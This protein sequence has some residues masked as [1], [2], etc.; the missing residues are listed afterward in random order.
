MPLY[1]GK[2]AICTFLQNMR[3]MLRSHDRYKPVSLIEKMGTQPTKQIQSNLGKGRIV[4]HFYSAGG[5]SNLQLRVLAV[6]FDPKSPLPLGVR[7]PIE[8]NVSL[9]PTSVPGKWHLNPSNGLSR[10]HERDR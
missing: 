7:D 2:Y 6:G 10:V 8:H 1:A 9:D 4:P 5:S 3:N